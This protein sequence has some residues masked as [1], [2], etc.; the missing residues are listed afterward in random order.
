MEGSR[1]GG[2]LYSL[3]GWIGWAGEGSAEG[4]A[5]VEWGRRVAM[6]GWDVVGRGIRG[7]LQSLTKLSQPPVTSRMTGVDSPPDAIASGAIA[8]DHETALQ[9]VT[10][11][12]EMS[13]TSHV[14][15]SFRLST[16]TDSSDD[17]HARHRPNSFGAQVIELTAQAQ[18]DQSTGQGRRRGC[19]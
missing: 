13:F 15:S 3:K 16:R 9:P 18:M 10:W 1:W 11:A 2:L 19:G 6:V 8:G 12:F 7:H 4:S 5:G 17:A 14:S